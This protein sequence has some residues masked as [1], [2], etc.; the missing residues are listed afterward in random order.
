[1]FFCAEVLHRLHS[2]FSYM[3]IL[4][5]LGPLNLQISFHTEKCFRILF[6]V[7]VSLLLSL[8]PFLSSSFRLGIGAIDVIGLGSTHQKN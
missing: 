1:M 4:H 7:F 5:A 8:M 2:C 6:I 3:H